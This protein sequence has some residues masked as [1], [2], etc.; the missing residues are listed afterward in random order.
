MGVKKKIIP[1]NNKVYCISAA[2]G[3]LLLIKQPL[4]FD[5]LSIL[6]CIMYLGWTRRLTDLLIRREQEKKITP[7][8]PA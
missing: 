7:P 8:M 3:C 4:Q 1:D 5:D 2:G 6:L